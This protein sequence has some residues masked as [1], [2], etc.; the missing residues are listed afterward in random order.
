MLRFHG[1]A[2]ALV[3][4]AFISTIP[5]NYIRIS[6]TLAP[7]AVSGSWSKKGSLGTERSLATI[8]ERAFAK[9]LEED[10]KAKLR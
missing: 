3:P 6:F 2:R 10:Q 7:V 8:E 9:K 5:H 4:S 1:R